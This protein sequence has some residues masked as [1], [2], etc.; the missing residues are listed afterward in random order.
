[1]SQTLDPSTAARVLDLDLANLI[2]KAKSGKPLSRHERELI[3]QHQGATTAPTPPRAVPGAG[4]APVA[5]IREKK[6]LAAALGISRPTLDTYLS[7]PGAPQRG[8]AG[9]PVEAVR[10]FITST[11]GN[12]SLAVSMNSDLASLKRAE[13][14]ERARKFRIQNDQRCG[15]LVPAEEVQREAGRCILATKAAFYANIDSITAAAAMKLALTGE[16][17]N[18]IRQIVHDNTVAALRNM[19]QGKWADV[20]CPHCSKELQ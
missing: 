16:Q 11:T 15:R 7:K 9:W 5:F 14:F 4:N 12:D 20:A 1:M 19:H 3:E 18:I 17:Q 2:T 6:K 8:P 10:Q 13:L